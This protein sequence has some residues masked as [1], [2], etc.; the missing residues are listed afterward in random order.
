[1]SRIGKKPISIPDGVSVKKEANRVIVN[2]PKGELDWELHP[3]VDI[4]IT[5]GIIIVRPV[6][7][8]KKTPAI[9]GTTRARIQNMVDGV[10]RGFE[11]K[12]EIEGIGYR[13]LLDGQNLQLS[14]GF[15]HPVKVPVPPGIKLSVEKNVIT[16]S[17]IDKDL[18]G[19][20]AARI[21]S[22]KKPEPYKGKGIRYQGEVVQRKQGK[23]AITTAGA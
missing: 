16:V 20:T 21:R 12:L 1:M 17:G 19:E 11:K 4:D 8:S 13:A 2:G 14:I 6:A 22:M 5:E 7:K 9:W 18:V 15:S 3:V 23:R 10:T